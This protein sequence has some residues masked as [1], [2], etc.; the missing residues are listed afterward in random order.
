MNIDESKLYVPYDHEGDTYLIA[1]PDWDSFC[2]LIERI[3]DSYE[4]H[5]NYE[6]YQEE[7][8]DVLWNI[9]KGRLGGKFHYIVLEKDL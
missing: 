6:I 7:L 4:E 3:E 5:N 9:P 1:K 2:G 8:W